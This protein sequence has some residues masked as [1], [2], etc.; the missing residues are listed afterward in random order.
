ME[1]WVCVVV[2]GGGGMLCDALC[3]IVALYTR[4]CIP[5]CRECSPPRDLAWLI[6][7]TPASVAATITHDDAPIAHSRGPQTDGAE[8]LDMDSLEPGQHPSK[9]DGSA[10]TSRRGNR[11]ARVNYASLAIKGKDR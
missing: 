6:Q 3:V 1:G 4:D 7:D 8:T 10:Q 5:L 9:E 11:T 2:G